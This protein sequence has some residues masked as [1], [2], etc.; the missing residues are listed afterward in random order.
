MSDKLENYL[1]EIGRYLTDASSREEI[2]TEIRSHILEKA[3][4]A[5]ARGDAAAL[6]KI[7]ADYGPARR[8][9]ERYLEGQD[10]IAPSYRRHLFRYTA[11]LFAAHFLLALLGVAFHDSFTVFPVLYVPAMGLFDLVMYLP[12]AFLADL[13]FVALILY[14][15]TR[16]KKDVKLPWPR[17]G[18]DLD[19]VADKAKPAFR[20]GLAGR[21][22]GFMAMLALTAA[23]AV[24]FSRHET[25]FFVSIH[26][27]DFRPLLV[28]EV[29]RSLSLLLIGAWGF[30]TLVAFVRIFFLSPWIAVASN[31]VSLAVVALFL[32]VPLRE[33]LVRPVDAH[34]RAIVADSL[35]VVFLFIALMATIDLVKNLVILGKRKLAADRSERPRR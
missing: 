33:A 1:E 34:V 6:E 4:E 9:A 2:L 16:S 29:G 31:V 32:R 8:V 10:I 27:T 15:V 24:I 22:F 14:F 19:E 23:A 35:L 20:S 13:G 30:G 26:G 7:I 5:G 25:I 28:P 21:I 11:L 12:M 18:V 17:F 3:E